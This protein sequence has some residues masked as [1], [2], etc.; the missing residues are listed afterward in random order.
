LNWAQRVYY[1][2]FSY[3]PI[4]VDRLDAKSCEGKTIAGTAVGLTPMEAWGAARSVGMMSR[5]VEEDRPPDDF[6]PLTNEAFL[7]KKLVLG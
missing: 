1:L 5:S 4:N 2:G 6:P 3:D 7:R